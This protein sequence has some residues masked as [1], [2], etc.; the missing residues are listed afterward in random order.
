M[1]TPM[2]G[3]TPGSNPGFGVVSGGETNAALTA[4]PRPHSP[5]KT[6]WFIGGSVLV[7]VLGIGVAFGA[8]LLSA[9]PGDAAASATTPAAATP[10]AQTAVEPDEPRPRVEPTPAA[11][12][13]EE[14]P[15]AEVK[16]AAAARVA[17]AVQPKKAVVAPPTPET[18]EA[19]PAPKPVKAVVKKPRATAPKTKKTSSKGIDIGY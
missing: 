2:P 6:P 5:S 3:L 14:S 4:T 13:E 17:P 18:V 12:P 1:G 9:A 8:K 16:P 19:R 7:L 10:S 11:E 15:A